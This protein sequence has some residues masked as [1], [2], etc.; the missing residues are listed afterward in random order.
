MLRKYCS[1]LPSKNLNR[2]TEFKFVSVV[3]HFSE[4]RES[5]YSHTS[6]INSSLHSIAYDNTPSKS[7]NTPN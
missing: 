3:Y 4:K 7:R 6:V 1:S 5:I 2:E